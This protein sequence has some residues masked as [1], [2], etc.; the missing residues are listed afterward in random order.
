MRKHHVYNWNELKVA[1]DLAEKCDKFEA[2]RKD[3]RKFKPKSFG[4]SSLIKS[5][6]YG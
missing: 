3:H 5:H 6:K 4:W 1:K 2:I